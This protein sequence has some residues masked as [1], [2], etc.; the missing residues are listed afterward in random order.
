MDQPDWLVAA[1]R[2]LGVREVVGARDNPRILAMFRDSGHE[3]VVRD[4]VAWCAAFVGACLERGG[5]RGTRSLMAR[6]YLQWGEDARELR[7]G[8]VAVLS[9]GSSPALGH[10]GFVVGE[11]DDK[12]LLLGGNQGQQVS[13]QAFPKSRLL[14][15]RWPV[16]TSPADEVPRR[17]DQLEADTDG[18]ASMFKS[19]LA[20]VLEMEGGYGDDPHDPGGPTNKGITLA[21]YTRWIGETV[22]EANR[23]RLVQQLR[24][25][26]D[27]MVREIYQTRYWQPAGCALMPG[28]LAFM[29]FDA[30]VNH[31][32]GSAVRMLQEAVG[33]AVDGEIGPETRGAI[34]RAPIR[35]TLLAYA[36]L[37]RERYRALDHFWRFGRGWLRRVDATLAGSSALIGAAPM[38]NSDTDQ[39]LEQRKAKGDDQMSS[40]TTSE[41]VPAK[42]WGE[43]LTIWGV[44]VTGLSTVVPVI[45]PIIGIDITADMIELLGNQVVH[46]AQAIGGLVGTLMTI[47]GRMRATT[48]IQRRVVSLKI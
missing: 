11:A 37:R 6:S 18:G 44:I 40:T 48:P 33:A 21:V 24:R 29:H 39:A 38:E 22:S 41:D 14:G 5:R 42:W 45:G 15:V 2:E 19:A 36:E 25:I 3:A 7:T 43:S 12:V 28:A 23:A 20:H 26:P 13:V 31:G 47:Y 32:V 9:R 8:S 10:V 35:K 17:A 4:E 46:V 34:A 30:A 1:W 16:G 27:A